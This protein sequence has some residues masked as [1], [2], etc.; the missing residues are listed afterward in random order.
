[1]LVNRIK[2]YCLLYVC[3]DD[4]LNLYFDM[5]FVFSILMTTL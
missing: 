5:I 1:L 2:L 4:V 3:A